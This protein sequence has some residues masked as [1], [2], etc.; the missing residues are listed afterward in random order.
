MGSRKGHPRGKY[1]KSNTFK[2]SSIV[3][4]D[5][6][7][8][9]FK[10]LPILLHHMKS[11]HLQYRAVCLICSKQFISKSVC[12]RHMKNLHNIKRHSKTKIK[13]KP[14]QEP[15]TSQAD[16]S[17]VPDR[18]LPSSSKAPTQKEN[19]RQRH[20]QKMHAIAHLS[21]TIDDFTSSGEPSADTDFVPDRSF[22]CM[23]NALAQNK[24][25]TFGNHLIANRD[26][27][28][29]EQL[30]FTSAFASVEYLS[31]T[32]PNCFNCGKTVHSKRK[33]HMLIQCQHCI[34]VWFCSKRC[35][36]NRLHRRNCNALYSNEDCKIVRLVT[37]M[38][39]VASKSISDIEQYLQFCS[40]ILVLNKKANNC[41]PPKSVYGLILGLKAK[42][43]ENHLSI[44]Q[45]VFTLVK[46]LPQFQKVGKGNDHLLLQI[47]LRHTVSVPLN[48]FSE[49]IDIAKGGTLHRFEI[50]DILSLFNHSCEPNVYNYINEQNISFSIAK[51]PIKKGE[52][53]FI[54]YFGESEPNNIE[55]R[56]R[57]L[58][59][60]WGFKCICSKCFQLSRA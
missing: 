29:G 49:A 32:G 51:R 10:R 18:L 22:P 11:K 26:I 5:Y 33:N 16:A 47:A 17:V 59:D 2:P 58:E 60:T 1:K 55:E 9:P 40:D 3:S 37:E 6:C 36:L 39:N 4:C 30:M 57:S 25:D 54:N 13:F 56:Q 41:R 14:I 28:V 45:R 46:R 7:N 12:H 27:D 35:S 31:C 21:M 8:K 19:E 15:S 50:Y 42:M 23:S 43:E 34:N 38:V 44:A 52:Q 24:N 48:S 53:V 20:Q